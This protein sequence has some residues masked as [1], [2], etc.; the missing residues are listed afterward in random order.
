[1]TMNPRLRRNLRFI[2]QQQD[3]VTTHVVKDTVSLKYYKFGSN[4]VGLMRLLDGTRSLDEV[5][6][7]AREQLGILTNADA[8]DRFI[9]RLKEMSLVERTQ[10]ECSA[11]Q[12]E[13]ARKSRNARMKGHGG[14]ILRMRFSLGDPDVLL[15][16]MN[17]KFG[18]FFTPAFIIAS[19]C[20][21]ALYVLILSTHWAAFTSGL[22][23]L[24]SPGRYTI[25]FVL[26]LY[27]TVTVIFLIHEFGHGL[28]CKHFGGE[29]H[30]IGV[31]LIY[32]LPAFFC[33]VND[34]WTFEKRSQRLW[35]TFAGGWIQLVLGSIAAV[36]WITTQA[37]TAV[38]D[39][40]FLSVLLGGGMTVL[41]NFNPLIPLDGY[42]ALVDWLGIPNL[43]KRAFEYTGAKLQQILKRSKVA[44]PRV[45]P[46]EARI[47]LTY[48]SL[49]MLYVFLILTSLGK[50]L[51]RFMIGT[52][53]W[54]GLALFLW[55]AWRA[56]GR[57][58]QKL[59]HAA[60]G[61]DGARARVRVVQLLQRKR[62]LAVVLGLLLFLLL[63]WTIKV[64]GPAV[65]ETLQRTVLRPP[66][67][68]RI[69]QLLVKEGDAVSTGQAVAVLSNPDLDIAFARAQAATVVLE[70]DA[71]AARMH[72]DNG[73]VRA[74]ELELAARTDMLDRLRARRAALLLRAPFDARVV[75]S[76][77]EE[78]LGKTAAAGDSLIELQSTGP[79]RARVFLAQRDIGD[80]ARGD[81]VHLKFPVRAAWT[82]HSHIAEIAAAARAGQVEVLVPLTQGDAD[83]P[84]MAGMVGM[85]KVTVRHTT[86]TGAGV[87]ALRRVFRP[88]FLL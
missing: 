27:A 33:N 61:F 34:A 86:V 30:E 4:E 28:T 62:T 66:E 7:A 75:T 69:D 17:R 71:N 51:G 15:G 76:H 6:S 45:T 1:M 87:R 57:L 31:M 78:L 5:A 11:L 74:A 59:R 80:L 36:V 42:Y 37:G 79:L 16:K 39:F 49:A 9:R 72:H 56:T 73:A 12:L 83:V 32:F 44:L 81:V 3:G 20:L 21:F 70:H 84:L 67:S 85:A 60:A 43:R 40:A 58:R 54:W 65:V 48:G 13:F 24:Y 63:P 41:V 50:K 29:V 53:G 46:R 10:E 35:V 25:N 68:G 26:M 55:L 2:E 18:F 8:I 88:D 52:W 23:T 64:S 14:T 19:A 38:N 22:H 77:V 47:F 82:W